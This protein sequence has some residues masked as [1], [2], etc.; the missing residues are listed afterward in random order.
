MVQWLSLKTSSGSQRAGVELGY[1]G[2]CPYPASVPTSEALAEH[3]KQD[4][5]FEQA[6]KLRRIL[7]EHLETTSEGWV[8]SDSWK[9][10]K[11]SHKLAF[12]FR[13]EAIMTDDEPDF[14]GGEIGSHMAVRSSRSINA[15]RPT[16]ITVEIET[17]DLETPAT[18]AHLPCWISR[19]ERYEYMLQL[20]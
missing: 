16:S 8:A 3:L 19:R 17:F 18:R 2:S 20:L 14:F 7:I 5:E 11:E 1:P 10:T 12:K 15:W 9:P 6:Q 13:S 4:K